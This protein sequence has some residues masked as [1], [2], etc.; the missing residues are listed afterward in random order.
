ML[1][2][3]GFFGFQFLVVLYLQEL[4][5]WSTIEASLAMLVIGIDVALAPTITP[6]LARRFG[7]VPVLLAGLGF[8]ALSFGLFLTAGTGTSYWAMLPSLVSMGL[9]FTLAYG[10]LTIIATNGIDEAEQG[11][12]GGLLYTSFQFGAAIGLAGVAAVNVAATVGG[13]PQALLDGYR[14][15]LLVPLGAAVLAVVIGAF[16]LGR[17]RSEANAEPAAEPV[18]ASV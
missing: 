16:N 13:S 18:A 10:P 3:A 9:A 4:R 5:G 12:A 6:K 11:L 1:F 15:A 7:N 2:M 17:Q 14:A 8:A